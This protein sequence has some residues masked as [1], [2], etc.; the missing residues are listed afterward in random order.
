[1]L[2]LQAHKCE[3]SKDKGRN[4]KARVHWCKLNENGYSK[5]TKVDTLRVNKEKFIP[6][7]Q[8]ACWRSRRKARRKATEENFFSVNWEWERGGFVDRD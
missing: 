4:F 6:N 3:D 1:M 5:E 2:L 7:C 8:T